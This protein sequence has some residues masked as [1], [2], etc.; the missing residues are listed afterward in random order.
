[1]TS[2]TART[3]DHTEN[4][5]K[6]TGQ[7][8]AQCKQNNAAGSQLQRKSRDSAQPWDCESFSRPGPLGSGT[9]S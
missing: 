5:H 6:C 8:N 2:W 7:K 1:M 4:I 9:E 3:E